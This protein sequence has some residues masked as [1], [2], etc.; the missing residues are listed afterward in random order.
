M[1]LPT[2]FQEYIHKS[3]YARYLWEDNR[4]ETWGETVSRYFDFFTE[5]LDEQ[6]G[7]KLTDNNRT[8]LQDAVSDLK[9][10]PSMRCL[11]TAGPALKRENVAGYNCSYRQFKKF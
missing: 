8:M 6:C 1:G 11:M 5:H 9:V 7:Y 2:S 4:R 10:M 3:R